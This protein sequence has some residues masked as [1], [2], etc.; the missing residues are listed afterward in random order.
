MRALA[1]LLFVAVPVTAAD[2]VPLFNGKD[3]T[4][5]TA[6]LRPPKDKPDAKPDP[7]DTWSVKDGVLLCTGKPN[8][9]LAT[10]KEYGDYTLTLKWRYPTDAKNPNSGVLLHLVGPDKVWPNSVEVQLKG[11]FAGDFWRNADADGKLPAL[12]VDAKRKDAADKTDRH[13]LRAAGADFEKAPGEWNECEILCE[14]GAIAVTVN[15]KKAN[16]ATGGA[17]KK[18]RIGLQ[19]EGSAVEFKDILILAK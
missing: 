5:W 13:F 6:T 10:A 2:F 8:G 12:D 4:G 18:G 16:E 19:S 7:K 14:A 3:L 1:L 17:L 11:G 15:G 9:Y